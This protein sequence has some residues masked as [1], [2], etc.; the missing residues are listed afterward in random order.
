MVKKQR[1]I[2][3]T[4]KKYITT[5]NAMLLK[6]QRRSH[7]EL[8]LVVSTKSQQ[9]RSE[10]PSAKQSAISP[11]C[12]YQTISACLRTPASPSSANTG[13]WSKGRNTAFIYLT[14][15][16]YICSVYSDE[17]GVEI[18]V[19]EAIVS[20]HGPSPAQMLQCQRLHSIT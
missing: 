6:H 14:K 16:A 5:R 18:S 13:M 8:I 10:L 12:E 7:K 4:E 19:F 15:W 20:S 9:S 2:A 17:I 1:N 11:R 3:S